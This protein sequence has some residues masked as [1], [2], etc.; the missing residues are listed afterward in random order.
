M[1]QHIHITIALDLFVNFFLTL[2]VFLNRKIGD[3]P[4]DGL[5]LV[6]QRADI[7]K[8]LRINILELFDNVESSLF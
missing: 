5:Q 1:L 8:S 4:R 3:L 7:E 6:N 2:E